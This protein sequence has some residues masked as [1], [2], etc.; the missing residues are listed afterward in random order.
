[1][2]AFPQAQVSVWK[3]MGHHPQRE[4]PSELAQFI[5]AACGRGLPSGARGAATGSEP[6]GGRVPAAALTPQPLTAGG[7]GELPAVA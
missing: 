6:Q 7:A 4:R 5:Q 1:M 2:T 3:K